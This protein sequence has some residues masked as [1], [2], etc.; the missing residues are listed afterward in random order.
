MK[1]FDSFFTEL[2]AMPAQ[3]LQLSQQVL[4]ERELLHMKI[5]GLEFTIDTQLMKRE[6]LRTKKMIIKEHE[7]EV[8]AN[9]NFEIKVM[10]AKKLKEPVYI[11]AMNCMQCEMTCHEPCN[12]NLPKA[13]C[14]A[15]SSTILGGLFNMVTKGEL[16]T[17]V[18]C[19]GKCHQRDHIEEMTKWVNKQVEET[20]TLHDV[21]KKYEDARQKKLSA[22][23]LVRDLQMEVD[24]LEDKLKQEVGEITN[25]LNKLNSIALHG[26]VL[27]SPDYI[28]LM[29]ENQKKNKTE[30]FMEKI[31]SLEDLLKKVELAEKIRRGEAVV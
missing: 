12:P 31:K 21:R 5:E 18:V 19:P 20:R 8:N 30:G 17:C 23:E 26:A 6:E 1:N 7:G 3:S 22:E 28:K 27:T 13:L 25:C 29:I 9:K 11:G 2:S 10:V 4:A 16:P 15:F 24:E 14:L